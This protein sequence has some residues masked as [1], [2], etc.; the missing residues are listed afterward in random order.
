MFHI[1]HEIE[2]LTPVLWTV[3]ALQEPPRAPLPLISLPSPPPLCLFVLL[4][5]HVDQTSSPRVSLAMDRQG[6][7]GTDAAA[8]AAQPSQN[9]LIINYL[10]SHV[11]EIELRVSL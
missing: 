2:Y 6:G 9:N 5:T 11:T 4:S 1:H 8:A 10:P 3:A 7:E